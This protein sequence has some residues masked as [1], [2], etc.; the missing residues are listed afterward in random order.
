MTLETIPCPSCGAIAAADDAFC[1]EC[2]GNLRREPAAA[3]AQPVHEAAEM[4]A[5]HVEA[6]RMAQYP[7]EDGSEPAATPAPTTAP[8][9]APTPVA[10]RSASVDLAKLDTTARVAALCGLLAFINSF[11]PWYT[12]SFDGVGVGSANAWDLNYAWNSGR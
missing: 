7:V 8:T 9:A 12:V 1:A 10:A 3:A 6:T 4:R 11:L 2:G 5:D